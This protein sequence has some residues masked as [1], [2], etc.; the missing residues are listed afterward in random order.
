MKSL[1]KS[2][3]RI[4]LLTAVGL[5]ILLMAAQHRMIYFPRKYAPTDAASFGMG[6]QTLEFSTSQGK[7]TAYFV[8][9]RSGNPA[10]TLWVLF[11]GNGGLALEWEFLVRGYPDADAAFLLIDYPGYGASEGSPNS[12][13]IME[14]A[15][16]A[17]AA[18]LEHIKLAEALDLHTLGHSLGAANALAFAAKH[19]VSRVVLISPFTSLRD[20]ARRTVGWPLCYLLLDNYDNRARLLQITARKPMP[21]VEILHGSVDKLI[22]VAMGRELAELDARVRFRE[23]AGMGHNDILHSARREIIE[24]MSGPA[25]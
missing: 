7:Q 13:R 25:Y 16:A 10:R 5:A 6:V 9:P 11:N 23:F 12:R 21:R 17:L 15:D 20:M 2:L 3:F 4:A 24:T 19:E 1:M 14:T 8:P 18:C 22:P